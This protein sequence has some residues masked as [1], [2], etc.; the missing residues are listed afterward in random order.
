MARGVLKK[1]WPVLIGILLVLLLF[2]IDKWAAPQITD[3]QVSDASGNYRAY[4]PMGERDNALNEDRYYFYRL[5]FIPGAA[6]LGYI[7]LTPDDCLQS[8]AIN[9]KNVD[10]RHYSEQERC[11][12]GNGFMVYAGPYLKAGEE[13]VLE[14]SVVNKGGA[15]G[16][17]ISSVLPRSVAFLAAFALAA[18]MVGWKG[19]REDR[20]VAWIVMAGLAFY[21]VRLTQAS[22]LDYT[23]D[24]REHL[25][26]LAYY[27]TYFSLPPVDM[28]GEMH[29]PPLY[30]FLGGIIYALA[31]GPDVPGADY[32]VL[33]LSFLCFA[34]F[35]LY[36]VR[37]VKLFALP[38]ALELMAVAA[39]V[40]WPSNLLHCCRVSNDVM[41]YAVWAAFFY[42]AA[43]WFLSGGGRDF[44]KS[45]ML[46]A[47]ALLVKQSA[48][49]L[50]II[51]AAA[52][53]WKRRQS[54][55]YLPA[56]AARLMLCL[57]VVTLAFSFSF[58]RPFYAKYVEK[59]NISVMIGNAPYGKEGNI[60]HLVFSPANYLRFNYDAFISPYWD[61]WPEGK[62]RGY[63]WN[64]YF[65]T[66]LYADTVWDGTLIPPVLNFTFFWFAVLTAAIAARRMLAGGRFSHDAVFALLAIGISITCMI[67]MQW[68]K[69]GVGFGDFRHVY[70]IMTLQVIWACLVLREVPAGGRVRALGAGMA[71]AFV[72]LAVLQQAVQLL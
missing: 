36:G 3:M 12:F 64:G 34:V 37:L 23:P 28:G 59:K 21:F 24:I 39:V 44:V 67:A 30:Y 42:Y 58:G 46:I 65:K 53:A 62:E 9:G 1:I 13:N 57:A 71:M 51:L 15:Y 61:A 50:I 41:M 49:I 29:Q 68:L 40:F 56:G 70:P 72:V 22:L 10:V 18:F 48:V 32:A 14:A 26:T 16:L 66:L 52:W 35:L 2:F 63:F 20:K 43:R 11:D 69:T 55:S 47:V 19:L 33:Y 5:R 25:D 54:A 38:R 27:A 6:A 4:N 45:C 8:V 31:G 60:H 17:S 7:R